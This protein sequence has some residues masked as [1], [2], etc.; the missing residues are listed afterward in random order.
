MSG[1]AFERAAKRRSDLASGLIEHWQA[2]RAAR[3]PSSALIFLLQGNPAG[4]MPP[5]DEPDPEPSQNDELVNSNIC[6][7]NGRIELC[8]SELPTSA[9]LRAEFGRDFVDRLRQRQWQGMVF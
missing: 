3:I 4:Q 6:C 5:A 2:A 8:L 1:V 9:T 7:S